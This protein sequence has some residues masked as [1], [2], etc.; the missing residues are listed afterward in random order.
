[1]RYTRCLISLVL[2]LLGCGGPP[3]MGLDREVFSTVDALYTAVGIKD[4]NQV[5]RCEKTLRELHA[6][7][8]LPQ[9]AWQALSGII[10]RARDGSWDSAAGEL[11]WFMKGQKR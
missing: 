9:D 11:R 7:G 10:G 6:A 8:K 4:M 3:H 5:E 1:M 2:V